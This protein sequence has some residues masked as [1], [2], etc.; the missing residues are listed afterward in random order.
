MGNNTED[1]NFLLSA[2]G[3]T[4][5]ES[6]SNEPLPSELKEELISKVWAGTTSE[7][8]EWLLLADNFGPMLEPH[9]FKIAENKG[10]KLSQ[11]VVNSP[12]YKR[13]KGDSINATVLMNNQPRNIKSLHGLTVE[14]DNVFILNTLIRK[15]LIKSNVLYNKLD[16]GDLRLLKEKLSDLNITLIPGDCDQEPLSFDNFIKS[17]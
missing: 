11:H 12:E 8:E 1:L 9:L 5:E 10:I 17:L 14:V 6:I 4:S 16:K 13:Y 3:Q 2:V 15:V 7:E